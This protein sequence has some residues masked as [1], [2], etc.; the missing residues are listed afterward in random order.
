MSWHC[1]S[2]MTCERVHHYIRGTVRIYLPLLRHQSVL[3]S[4]LFPESF[5]LF[6]TGLIKKNARLNLTLLRSTIF[7]SAMSHICMGTRH[8][9]YL[10]SPRS[11]SL[12]DRESLAHFLAKFGEFKLEDRAASASRPCCGSLPKPYNYRIP[13]SGSLIRS[14]PPLVPES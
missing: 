2:L 9:R 4:S 8:Y 1:R 3:V 13:T 12:S 10:P 5:L 7:K 14:T 11:Q 6:N